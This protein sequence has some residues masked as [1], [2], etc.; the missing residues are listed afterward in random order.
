MAMNFEELDERTRQYMEQ[1]F[2]AELA[3]GQGYRSLDLIGD[4]PASFPALMRDAIRSGTERSLAA[5]LMV[6]GFWKTDRQTTRSGA[7]AT[8][9]VNVRQTA[10]RL[11]LSEFNTWYVRGLARR[12]LDEGVRT[13]QVYRAGDPKGEPAECVANE[14]R[15]LEVQAIYDGHRARY[16]PRPGNRTA[17]SIPSHPNCHHTIRRR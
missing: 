10:E 8:E 11:A 17:I 16:W 14:G 5:S 12:L 4:G 2:E 15:V 13:C 1:E 6:P 3:S 9:Q 7:P